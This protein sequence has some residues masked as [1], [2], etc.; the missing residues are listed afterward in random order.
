MSFE[1][2]KIG[3]FKIDGIL[4]REVFESERWRKCKIEEWIE[5]DKLFKKVEEDW[6]VE[7]KLFYSFLKLR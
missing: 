4:E 7:G 6:E 3:I 5:A 2:I 1:V